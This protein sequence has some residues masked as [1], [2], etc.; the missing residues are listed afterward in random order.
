MNRDV[1]IGDLVK[2]RKDGYVGTVVEMD[3]IFVKLDTGRTA[4]KFYIEVIE[5]WRNDDVNEFKKEI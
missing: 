3:D 1:K 2:H 4:L 5:K